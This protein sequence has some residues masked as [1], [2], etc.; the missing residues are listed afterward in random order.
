MAL[1]ELAQEQAVV[2][3]QGSRHGAGYG[4]QHGLQGWGALSQAEHLEAR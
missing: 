3:G 2:F 1:P 4:W